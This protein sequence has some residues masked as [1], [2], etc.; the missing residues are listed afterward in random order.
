[1]EKE[2]SG[3]VRIVDASEFLEFQKTILSLRKEVASLRELVEKQDISIERL[4]ND[5]NQLFRKV[6]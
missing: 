2:Y 1:M 3:M 4:N 5:V 6:L